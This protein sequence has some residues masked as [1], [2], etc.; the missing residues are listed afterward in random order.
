MIFITVGTQPQPFERLI[1]EIINLVDN[2]FIKDRIIIQSGS[3]RINHCKIDSFQYLDSLKMEQYLSEADL[4]ISHGGTGSII[5][6]LKKGKKVIGVPRMKCFGEH[7]N[8]HQKDLIDELSGGGFILPVYKIE[9]LKE[10]IK[11]SKDFVPQKFVSGTSLLI[12]D[13]RNFI[14][15]L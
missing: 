10:M 11:K 15:T 4:I 1:K 3:F 14:N 2:G 13:I 7:L 6:A 8:D 5:P 9:D 12:E